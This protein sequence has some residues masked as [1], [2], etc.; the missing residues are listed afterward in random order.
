MKILLGKAGD[1]KVLL[2]FEDTKDLKELEIFS[3]L[4]ENELFKGKLGEIYTSLNPEGKHDLVLGLGKKEDLDHEALREAFYKLGKKLTSLKVKTAGVD[5][6][7]LEGL[8]NKKSVASLAEGLLHSEY[9]FDKYKT[10]KE[11]KPSLETFYINALDRDQDKSQEAIDEAVNILDGIFLTRDL[12]NEPAIVLTPKE[13]ARRATEEL[14]PLGVKVTVYGKKE[15]EELGMEA[16]LSVALGSENEPQF[17]V[18]EYLEGGDSEKLALVGKGLTYDTGGYSLKPSKSMDTMFTD[19]GG[20]A[21]VIGAL[22]SIAKSKLPKNVVGIVAACENAI[23]GKAYKP[24]DIISSMSGK[25]IEVENTDA[26]GRLTLA[27]AL[28]YAATVVKADKIIDL[29][30]LTGA[31]VVALSDVATGAVTNNQDLM[32]D[33]VKASKRAGEHVWQLPHFKEFDKRV[34][35]DKADLINTSKGPMGAGTITAGLF[36]GHFVNDIPWVHLD[37]A[38]TAYIDSPRTYLP[39][40]AT[41]IPVSTLYNYV[42]CGM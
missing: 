4:K 37:I 9:V 5:L 23:S 18:M 28:W 27:D 15:I 29:A 3:Y 38:G 30:T 35:S 39:K 40:G 20:S 41:G 19:M 24:G 6:P 32:K 22:K 26:E 36:L 11:F 7:K 21:S 31:C 8:C 1:V 17:I 16:F 33:I 12:V 13:L 42:K 34:V 2:A 25:T 14:E 10:E